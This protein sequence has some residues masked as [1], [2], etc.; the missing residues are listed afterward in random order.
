MRAVS[1]KQGAY[2][3]AFF[4]AILP[5]RKVRILNIEKNRNDPKIYKNT[6]NSGPG[7]TAA[8]AFG[9]IKGG[10]SFFDVSELAVIQT[11]SALMTDADVD[12]GPYFPVPYLLL[13]NV[14]FLSLT[15][16]ENWWTGLCVHCLVSSLY[17]V[18]AGGRSHWYATTIRGSLPNSI[19]EE[20][21][22]NAITT[23]QRV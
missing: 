13:L 1:A 19:T 18:R 9:G 2:R 11:Q 3:P 10:K 5:L 12:G 4:Q 14:S 22:A 23:F 7:F 6:R 21:S 8:G 16:G 20:F 17:K 15:S